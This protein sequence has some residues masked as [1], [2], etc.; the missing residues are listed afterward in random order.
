M[1]KLIVFIDITLIIGTILMFFYYL[2]L[3][4]EGFEVFAALGKM[5]ISL[6]AICAEVLVLIIVFIIRYF[7]R[8]RKSGECNR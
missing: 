7:I 1:I 2:F 8:K 5:V 3:P 4:T 6:I